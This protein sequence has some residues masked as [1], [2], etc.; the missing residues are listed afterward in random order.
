MP[1][2][3]R[4]DLSFNELADLPESSFEL[5]RLYFGHLRYTNT[6]GPALERPRAPLP[7]HRVAIG[8]AGQAHPAADQDQILDEVID[9]LADL[10]DAPAFEWWHHEQQ[11]T[12]HAM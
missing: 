12:E 2:L 10:A 3:R 5:Q 9:D 6:G 7:P 11:L 1:G 4:L 8:R